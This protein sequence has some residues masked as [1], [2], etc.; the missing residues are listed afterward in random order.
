MKLIW[1][2]RA[3]DIASDELVWEQELPGFNPVYPISDGNYGPEPLTRFEV[4]QDYEQ[5]YGFKAPTADGLMFFLEAE[6]E[7]H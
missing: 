7:N 3:Y 6:N 4:Q 1:A 5:R 2:L